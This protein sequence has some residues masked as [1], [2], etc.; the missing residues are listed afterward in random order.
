MDQKLLAQ[1][2]TCIRER[3][4]NEAGNALIPILGWIEGG[5]KSDTS[6]PSEADATRLA[7]AITQILNLMR[8]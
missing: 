8:W 6:V 4:Y 3:R 2:E 7:A 1:L 5:S